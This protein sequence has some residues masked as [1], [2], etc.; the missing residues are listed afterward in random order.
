MIEHLFLPNID[1]STLELIPEHRKWL[2]EWLQQT[3]QDIEGGIVSSSLCLNGIVSEILLHGEIRTDWNGVIRTYLKGSSEEPLAYSED[4]GKL[5][6]KYN[7]WRQTPIHAIHTH[8]WISK[9]CR[10]SQEQISM[11]TGLVREFIQPNGWVYNP[12]V[13]VTGINTRMKSELMMS[14]CMGIEVLLGGELMQS[15]KQLFETVLSSTSMTGYL[16]AEYFRLTALEYLQS[17]ELAPINLGEIFAACRAGQGYCDFSAEAKVDDYMGT[18]KRTSRD[19]TVHSAIASIQAGYIGNFL[20]GEVM[21]TV[22]DKLQDFG[23]YLVLHPLDIQAF[24]MRDIDVPFGV[25]I[26]P[27]EIIAASYIISMRQG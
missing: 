4:Y 24:R 16:S 7:Q 26:T 17:S 23:K 13:S 5:L 25:D 3:E 6:N 20:G 2:E 10:A 9:L 12:S 8:W 21:K 14:L 19:I 15:N 1:I 22:N 18:A 27:L 11:Y